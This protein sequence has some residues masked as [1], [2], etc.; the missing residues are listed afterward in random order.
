[1]RAGLGLLFLS[2]AVA[3]CETTAP[4]SSSSLFDQMDAEY[5]AL[6]QKYGPDLPVDMDVSFGCM[7]DL[8]IARSFVDENGNVS[9][10]DEIS[11]SVLRNISE[12]YRERVRT[13]EAADTPTPAYAEG[14]WQA[15]VNGNASDEDLQKIMDYGSERLAAY[16]AESEIAFG[17]S[18]ETCRK[19]VVDRMSPEDIDALALN[20]VLR[21]VE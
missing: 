20:A 10:D 19:T 13:L 6:L 11:N 1:M 14:W 3:G 12:V 16:D 8:T 2:A 9:E 18:V 4:A 17:D 5:E 21:S 7:M 15:A